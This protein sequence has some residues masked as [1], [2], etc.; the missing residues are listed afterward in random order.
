MRC[1]HL[2]EFGGA[3][4][5]MR[6]QHSRSGGMGILISHA[7]ECALNYS[8]HMYLRGVELEHRVR[9]SP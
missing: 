6:E 2:F 1:N 8:T 3:C 4:A 5:I 7:G 9:N